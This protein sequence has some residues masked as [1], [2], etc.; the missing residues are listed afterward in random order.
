MSAAHFPR[1][2]DALIFDL[3]GVLTDT[4][5]L[6]YAA[7]Q[8]LADEIGVPFDATVNRRLKGVDR[9]ASLDIVL[10]RAERHFD[11]DERNALAARKNAYY[12]ASIASFGPD[13]LFHGARALLADARAAG[14][15]TALA[16]ASRNA[17]AL[18]RQLG[19]EGALDVVVDAA[20]IPNA[21]P[22]PDVFLAA[23]AALGVAPAR[24]IGIEDAAAGIWA[25]H[26][27]GMAAIGIGDP[28]E[29]HRADIVLPDIA[30]LRLNAIVAP[31]ALLPPPAGAE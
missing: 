14:L 30:A 4:A 13:Q 25:I 11:A 8:R 1:A 28:R 12:V 6:H 23:A 15:R 26:A 29:L 22:A 21:K 3:D 5:E 7:W 20:T 24:C 16:S 17:G 19:I 10:E 27:A 9:M 31:R 2:C 18:V